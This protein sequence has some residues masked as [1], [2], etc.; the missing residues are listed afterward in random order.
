MRSHNQTTLTIADGTGVI[1]GQVTID[2]EGLQEGVRF[3]VQAHR[4]GDEDRS[5]HRYAD[6]DERGR[7]VIE[8]LIPGEYELTAG[9]NFRFTS[10]ARIPR[11]KPITQKVSVTSTTE[12][13]VTMVFQVVERPKAP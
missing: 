6:T 7:F 11:L 13:V 8:G 1:R 5:G 10:N 2:G 9:S 4:L 3:Q 12:S